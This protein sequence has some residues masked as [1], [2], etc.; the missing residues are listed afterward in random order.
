MTSSPWRRYLLPGAGFA[1]FVVAVVW[2]NANADQVDYP[3]NVWRMDLDDFVANIAIITGAAY[4]IWKVKRNSDQARALAAVAA[5]KAALL[6]SKFNGGLAE[7]AR[8]HMQDN[9]M[10]ELLMVRVDRMEKERDDCQE[11]LT[12]LRMWMVERL[13]QTGRGRST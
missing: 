4:G 5:E 1:A 12:D 13:D 7:A 8:T 3:F 9:E 2:V 11:A 6:E 10:F